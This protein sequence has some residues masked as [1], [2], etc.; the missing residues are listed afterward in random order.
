MQYKILPVTKFNEMIFYG[1]MADGSAFNAK[2]AVKTSKGGYKQHGY[3]LA[4]YVS[5]LLST[6]K[7]FKTKNEAISYDLS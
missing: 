5:G 7:W 4:V 1:D 6:V 3:V 2:W